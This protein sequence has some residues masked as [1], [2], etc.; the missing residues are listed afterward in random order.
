[1]R[2]SLQK[3]VKTAIFISSRSFWEKFLDWFPI[4][5]VSNPCQK[6]FYE[7]CRSFPGKKIF[8][9]F[10]CLL[11]VW[12]WEQRNSG[13]RKRSF[14]RV[15]RIAYYVCS[16]NVDVNI[17]SLK[18]SDEIYL[19]QLLRNNFSHFSRTFFSGN[20]RNCVL[21]VKIISLRKTI[22]CWKNWRSN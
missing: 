21:L 8:K 15:V 17:F 18:T 9:K 20:D 7:F 13:F 16:E 22:L 1:M 2:I 4:K 12:D 11:L 19:I 5:I 6:V 14:N 3:F 10:H